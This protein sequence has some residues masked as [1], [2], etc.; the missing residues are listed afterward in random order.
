VHGHPVIF[1]RRLFDEL[2]A[3]DPRV[4][5]KAVVRGHAASIVNVPVDDAGAFVDIDTPADYQRALEQLGR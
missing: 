1:D 5:A 2:R 3:C 4:G